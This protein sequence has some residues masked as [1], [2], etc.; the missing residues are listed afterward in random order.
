MMNNK[1]ILEQWIIELDQQQWTTKCNEH[2][3]IFWW[4]A[5]CNGKKATTK[6]ERWENICKRKM[7]KIII[8]NDG[9]RKV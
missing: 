6:Q 2:H 8:I 9:E 3:N 1:N 7:E 4:V 5:N